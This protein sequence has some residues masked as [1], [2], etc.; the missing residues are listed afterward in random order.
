METKVLVIGVGND[1]RCD[2]AAG[3]LVARKLGE[4]NLPGVR[5]IEQSGEGSDL[6]AAWEGQE[7]VYL[8]DAAQSGAE[9]GT[10]HRFEAHEERLP[11]ESLHFS[12][13]AF[14]VAEAI[15]IAHSLGQLPT[16]LVVFGIEG[17]DFSIGTTISLRV[18]QA[19]DNVI[20]AL[21]G[22]IG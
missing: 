16:K 18:Q 20:Y 14:G 9:P 3:L 2:D 11:K 7:S 13:H 4:R 8:I 22:E 19:V 10:I 21:M 15:N 17:Q 6:I 12:S 1:F 5:I